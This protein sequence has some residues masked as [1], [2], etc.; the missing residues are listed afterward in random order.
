MPLRL[1]DNISFVRREPAAGAVPHG[2]LCRMGAQVGEPLAGA[3][4]EAAVDWRGHTL[5]L[6][7]DDVPY[8]D[9]LRIYL[10]DGEFRLLDAATLGA[11]YATGSFSSLRLSDPNEVWFAFI[12]ESNWVL[13]LL[14][15]PVVGLPFW[16]ESKWVTRT[17]RILRHFRLRTG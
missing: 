13:E 15:R 12:G 14:D 4:L 8:E 5:V 9:M 6:L 16:G 1:A 10:F 7:S 11:M 2:V 17:R 3:V